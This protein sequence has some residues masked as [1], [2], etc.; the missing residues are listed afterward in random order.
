MHGTDRDPVPE[1][2]YSNLARFAL[3]AGA[4]AALMA[5]TA[6]AQE[7]IPPT[8]SGWSAFAPRTQTAPGTQASSG[9]SGYSLKILGNGVP[10][11]YGG[12]KTSIQGLSGQSH[13]RF[14]ARALPL[15]IASARESV[16]ILLRW[17]GSFGD[18]VAPDYVWDYRPQ[19]D[20]TLLFD[21][22]ISAPSGTTAVDIELVLQWSPSGQVTFD[23]LSFMAAAAP[24]SRPVR[25]AAIYY[26]PSGT[27]SGQESVRQAAAFAE[28]VAINHQPD[29]MVLGELL[30][31]IGVTGSLDSKAET[32]PGPSTDLM[33]EIARSHQVNI[34]F[35]MLEREGALLYN[36]AVLLDRNGDVAGK[37][38]K[39]QLPLADAYG[40]IAPGD[41]V[42]VFDTDFGRVALLI[43]QDLSFPEPAR[44]AAF[45]GAEM[46]LVPFWGGRASLVRARAVEHGI[47]VVTSGYDYPSE[48][49]NPLGTVVASA[50]IGGAPKVAIANIDLGQI[51]REQWLGYWRDAAN[52]ERRSAPYTLTPPEEPPEEPPP[53]E[54]PDV[55]ITAPAS[56]STVSG[57]VTITASASD[58]VGVV[59]VRFLVDGAPLGAED[60]S[61]P[62][63]ISWNTTTVAN[64]SH[65]L[66]ATARDTAGQVASSSITVNVGNGGPVVGPVTW[67]SLV[68]VTVTGDTL[69]KTSGCN[70]CQ[71][72]GAISVQSIGSG[73]GYVELTASETTTQRMIGLSHDNTDTRLADIDFG[74]LFWPAG[75]IDVRENGVYRN[76]ETTYVPGDVFRIAVSSGVVKYYKNGTLFFTSPKAP[77]YPLLV[78]TSFLNMGGTLRAVVLS[79]G[80]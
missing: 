13:Y 48:V 72:A 15:N 62:Y 61:S 40:G 71:D 69:K 79:G 78:D 38:R 4:L 2:L 74:L 8:P 29:I 43:C 25:V 77:T 45:Q 53:D 75:G 51:F 26:R 39:V 5:G 28:Q 27:P 56:G 76:A 67:T 37:F 17:R 66:T 3:L 46:L 58:D 33:A 59:G 54:P 20:G 14:R 63:S 64:G 11:V 60:T 80:Q 57:S 7:L 44:Q 22:V 23:Q 52:K 47:Y 9:A 70:G 55:S 41:S 10:A 73:N 31:V 6:Q 24:A 42:P 30:N 21:K 12:W 18:E 32:I 35:G 68:N 50:A 1:R 65:T 49:V 36:A 19:T 34:V 16:T